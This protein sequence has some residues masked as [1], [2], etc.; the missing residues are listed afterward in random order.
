MVSILYENDKDEERRDHRRTILLNVLLMSSQYCVVLDCIEM[1]CIQVV[2]HVLRFVIHV[3]QFRVPQG[4][5][6]VLS[7]QPSLNC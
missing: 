3:C 5:Y 7:V 1:Y 2:R 6:G 4:S